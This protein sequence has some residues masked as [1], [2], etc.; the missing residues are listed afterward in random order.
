[1]VPGADVLNEFDSNDAHA[2]L[3]ILGPGL[4]DRRQR[5]TGHADHRLGLEEAEQREC[6]RSYV[7]SSIRVAQAGGDGRGKET[8]PCNDRSGPAHCFLRHG[9]PIGK[10]RFNTSHTFIRVGVINVDSNETVQIGNAV[11]NAYAKKTSQQ[12]REEIVRAAYRVFSV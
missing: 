11:S 6:I 10:L 7:G 12:L 3:E 5:N 9:L 1:M 8:Q 2:P 4:Y